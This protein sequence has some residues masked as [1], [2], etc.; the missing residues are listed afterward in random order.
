MARPLALSA[1]PGVVYSPKA[2]EHC[3]RAFAACECCLGSGTNALCLVLGYEGQGTNGQAIGSGHIT[4]H[5]RDTSV[6]ELEEKDGIA[7]ASRSSLA[8]TSVA[9]LVKT[10]SGNDGLQ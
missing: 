5:K 2:T 9:C 3:A 10:A 7:G 4:A 1:S 8:M 6:P